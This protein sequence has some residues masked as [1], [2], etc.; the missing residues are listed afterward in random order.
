MQVKSHDDL[1]E[2]KQECQYTAIVSFIGLFSF[3]ILQSLV[4][5]NT[6]F[7]IASYTVF[8]ITM[9]ITFCISSIYILHKNAGY[10]REKNLKFSL[11]EKKSLEIETSDIKPLDIKS[12]TGISIDIVAEM[13]HELQSSMSVPLEWTIVVQ[14]RSGFVLFM[15]HL[16]NEYSHENLLFISEVMQFKLWFEQK[17]VSNNTDKFQNNDKILTDE[18]LGVM[19]KLPN[20]L[21]ISSIITQ[22]YNDMKNDEFIRAQMLFNKYIKRDKALYEVNIS[23]IQRTI[24]ENYFANNDADTYITDDNK[25]QNQIKLLQ[26][27]DEALK[28]IEWLLKDGFTR[29]QHSDQFYKYWRKKSGMRLTDKIGALFS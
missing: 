5:V 20:S 1:F 24:L 19:Y 23:D 2:I 7:S 18:E 11:K 6:V 15:N 25:W 10:D 14:H 17:I 29:F 13:N 26:I 8:I 16:I 9:L 27:Y 4:K 21:P 28:D 22:E 3:I 12:E